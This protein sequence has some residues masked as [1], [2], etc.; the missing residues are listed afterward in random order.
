MGAQLEIPDSGKQAEG[1]QREQC[2]LQSWASR[3]VFPTVPWEATPGV[4]SSPSPG[5]SEQTWLIDLQSEAWSS[6]RGWPRPG[7]HE[8]SLMRN[9]CSGTWKALGPPCQ[10]GLGVWDG[11][12]GPP[13][14]AAALGSESPRPRPLLHAGRAL[15]GQGSLSLSWILHPTPGQGRHPAGF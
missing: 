8:A 15:G 10:G 14:S 5:G 7:P 13:A 12:G 4:V 1:V 11:D 3:E 9:V 6:G 2:S